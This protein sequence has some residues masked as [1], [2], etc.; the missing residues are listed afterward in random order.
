M[1]AVVINEVSNFVMCVSVIMMYV[2]LY[3]DKTKVVHKWSFVG[4]W[5]LKLGLIGIILGSALN[6]LTL[7]DP[8]LTEV[9]LNVGLA[10]TFVWAYLFHRKMFRERLG[11]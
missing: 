5:T 4:H 1:V 8:P 7:S 10:L 2:Y 3:G 6:V 9:V 11:K